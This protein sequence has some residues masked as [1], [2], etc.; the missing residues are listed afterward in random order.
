MQS[1]LYAEMQLFY[2]E[3][4]Y[5]HCVFSGYTGTKTERKTVKVIIF[6]FHKQIFLAFGRT[7]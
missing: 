3:L 5:A 2:F 1:L 7:S 4:Y 6:V